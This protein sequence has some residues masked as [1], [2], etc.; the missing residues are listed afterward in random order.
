MTDFLRP[1]LELTVVIPG[2]L[3]AYLPLNA[4]LKHSFAR[5]LGWVIPVFLIL[6]ILGGLLC[7][8]TQTSTALVLLFMILGAIAV[9]VKTLNVSVWKS[10]SI[11]LAVCAVF[12]CLNSIS[13]ALNA[14]MLE[15]LHL[16]EHELWFRIPAA[17][18]YNVFC[19]LFVL[20]VLYPAT[21]SVRDLTED[22]NLARTWY[23]FWVLPLVFIALNLFMV[24]RYQETLYSGRILKGYIII[25]LTLLLILCLFYTMFFLM[26]DSLNRNAKLQQENHFLSMQQARYD[27]LCTAIEEARHA[28]HDMRHHFHQLSA[29]AENGELEEIKE[30]LFQADSRIPSLD[31]KFC[32]NRAADS[33]IGYY[34]SLAKRANIP[35]EAQVDLPVKVPVDEIDM[36]LVLSNLLENA[37]EASLKTAVEKRQIQLKAYLHADSLLLIQVEN[38]FD[39]TIR[40]K[41]GI[42]QSSKRKGNGVGIQSVRRISEK[43]GGTSSFTHANGVFTA[44]VMLH[45]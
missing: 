10:G 12:A 17:V 15:D 7:R 6:S 19:W 35:F 44:K 25:S 43:S 1:F 37:L 36:C 41:N 18:L 16:P 42:F 29:M 8:Q 45:K 40:E 23:V 26:A 4:F 28:R 13:R 20:I 27:N 14:V 2:L 32:E 30:Y 5:L 9:Y 34:C 33:V 3:L 24:P 38:T 11:A 39:G 31:M 22:D 21:H